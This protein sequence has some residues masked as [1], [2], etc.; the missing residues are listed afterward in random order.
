[1]I[2]HSVSS[3]LSLF[4]SAFWDLANSRP[5]HSL[6]LSSHLFL[7][8]PRLLPPF[9]LITGRVSLPKAPILSQA[10]C[11][12]DFVPCSGELRAQKFK[13]HLVKIQSL[14][15]L[16]LKHGV[17]Q[18]IPYILPLLP[19]ISSF[20]FFYPSGPFTCIFSKSPVFSCVG[21]G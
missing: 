21:C 1:M 20:L 19:W 13:A 14:N 5:V 3:I 4:R 15:V 7:C 12:C 17:G 11:L 6:T 16:P 2:S 10:L 8:L 18:Y 9:T